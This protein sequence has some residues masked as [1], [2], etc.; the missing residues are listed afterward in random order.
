[1]ECGLGLVFDLLCNWMFLVY[2]FK[3]MLISELGIEL[4]DFL[5]C[6]FCFNVIWE[7]LL[8]V[9]KYVGSDSV[10]VILM[11]EDNEMLK[12]IVVD[13]GVG[14]DFEFWYDGIGLL[15]IQRWLEMVGGSLSID[16][17]MNVGIIVML[18]VFCGVI[19]QK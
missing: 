2:G 18:F 19:Q 17:Q 4:V 16:S 13:S 15:N 12:V 8:N 3:V 7:F 5:V 6:F 9:V 14:F 11:L 1:M 10:V